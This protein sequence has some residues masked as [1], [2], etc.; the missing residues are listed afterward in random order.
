MKTNKLYPL[1]TIVYLKDGDQKIMIIGRGVVFK[2]QESNEERFVDYIGCAY[3]AGI[4]PEESIY[5][6]EEN[7]DK[8]LFEG[9]VDDDETRFNELYKEWEKNLDVP[10]KIIK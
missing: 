2:D 10:K 5:F 9:F 7:I 3:P 4:N 8:V 6:N 1:G